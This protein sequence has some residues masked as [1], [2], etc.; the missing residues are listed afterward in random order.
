MAQNLLSETAGADVATGA[1]ATLI[2]GVDTGSVTDATVKQ[3]V[4]PLM[5]EIAQ[6]P[7]VACVTSPYGPTYGPN[8]PERK[9]QANPFP[10]PPR[11][12]SQDRCRHRGGHQSNLAHQ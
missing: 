5:E 8:C 3:T 2:W 6:Q 4:T 11:D 10:L 9:Q 12:P 7:G 1:T